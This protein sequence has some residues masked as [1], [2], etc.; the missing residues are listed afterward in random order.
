MERFPTMRNQNQETL[1]DSAILEM[2]DSP[3]ETK[4]LNPK[5]APIDLVILEMKDFPPEPAIKFNQTTTMIDFLIEE[6]KKK[7]FPLHPTIDS[8]HQTMIDS[9]HQMIIQINSLRFK[10]MK[11]QNLP[12]VVTAAKISVEMLFKHWDNCSTL[13]VSP[14]ANAPRKLVLKNS[15]L[16]ITKLTVNIATNL[17]T[18]QNVLA[19]KRKLKENT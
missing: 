3:P 9:Q 11:L 18:C 17:P 7:D 6:M 8:Q 4:M 16:K 1:I 19:A 13:N 12:N 15:M 2:K 14:V 5:E 10:N